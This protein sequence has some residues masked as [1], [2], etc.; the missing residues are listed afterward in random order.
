MILIKTKLQKKRRKREI[1]APPPQFHSLMMRSKYSNL[2]STLGCVLEF[3]L[4]NQ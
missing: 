1:A 4:P 2:Q 3:L